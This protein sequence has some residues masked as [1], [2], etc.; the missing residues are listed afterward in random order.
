MYCI[1]IVFTITGNGGVSIRG[2][3]GELDIVGSIFI[4]GGE[5]PESTAPTCPPARVNQGP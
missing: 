5:G 2:S 3:E 4:L 1:N